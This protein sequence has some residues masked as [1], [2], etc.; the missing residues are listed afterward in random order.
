MSSAIR[1]LGQG[2]DCMDLLSDDG[3]RIRKQPWRTIQLAV[4]A[5]SAIDP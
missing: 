3:I 5:T 4:T 1:T 2:G